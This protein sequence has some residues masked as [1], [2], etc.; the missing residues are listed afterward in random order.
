[1]NLLK[2]TNL[3]KNLVPPILYE[4]KKLV[5]KLDLKQNKI[6]CCTNE[7]MMHYKDNEH[8]KYCKFCDAIY[9]IKI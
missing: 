1:M 5:S 2:E 3:E 7:C 6:S 9:L 8:E 4:T